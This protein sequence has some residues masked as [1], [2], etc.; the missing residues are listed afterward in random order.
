MRLFSSG[1]QTSKPATM[2][3][4]T[5]IPSFS[6]VEMDNCVGIVFLKIKLIQQVLSAK[7]SCATTIEEG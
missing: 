2:R 3:L 7:C 5:L 6:I 4:S 1:S